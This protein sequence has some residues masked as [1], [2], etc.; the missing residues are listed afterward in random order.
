[1]TSQLFLGAL[2]ACFGFIAAIFF[3]WG[4]VVLSTYEI[5]KLSGTYWDG[6]NAI[7]DMFITQRA[8]FACGAI[9]IAISFVWQIVSLIWSDLSA[10]MMFESAFYGWV[11]VIIGAL[12]WLAL[13]V[14]LRAK[15]IRKTLALVQQLQA[16]E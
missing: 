11:S 9:S 6:N 14:Y 8:E 3:A 15:L 1:M 2:S 10:T 13:L 5:A 12:I 4:T 16:K 7:R